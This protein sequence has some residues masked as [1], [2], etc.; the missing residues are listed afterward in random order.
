MRVTRTE[1]DSVLLLEPELFRDERGFLF[2]GYNRDG[3]AQATGASVEFVVD[4]HSSSKKGVLRGIHYQL[5]RPQAKV[6]SVLA[7]KVLDVVVDLRRSSSTFARWV[8]LELSSENRRSVWIPPGFGHAFLVVSD[9]ADLLYKITEY[10]SPDDS[11]TI[12]WDD[13][14]LNIPWPLP[15]GMSAPILSI[16]DR[17]GVALRDADLFE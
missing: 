13:P 4:V 9:H 12:R 15:N 5:R 8:G 6:V 3:H 17:R 16:N 1:L 14:V 2:E 10:H 7:G 11:R